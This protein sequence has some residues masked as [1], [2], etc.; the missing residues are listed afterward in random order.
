MNG[1]DL[2]FGM[3]TIQDSFLAETEELP[4]NQKSRCI[5]KLFLIAA[6]ISSLVV[7]AFAGNLQLLQENWFDSFFSEG[8]RMIAEEQLS[9]HQLQLLDKS[10]TRIDQTVTNQGFSVTMESALCDG[11]RMLMKCRIDAPEQTVMDGVNYGISA[12]IEVLSAR[13]RERIRSSVM[14][15]SS[16]ILADEN[17]KDNSVTMLMEID[18]QPKENEDANFINGTIISISIPQIMELTKFEDDLTWNCLCEGNWE[19]NIEF[20]DSILCAESFEV[21]DKPMYCDAFMWVDNRILRNTNIPLRVK[22]TSI[23]LRTLSAAIN[24]KRP[25]V[26][27]YAGVNPNEPIQIVMHDGSVIT[28]KWK[29]SSRRSNFDQW[30]FVFS[31]SVVAKDVA[32]IDFPGGT[33]IPLS[34]QGE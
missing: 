28:G 17:P 14:S 10:L 6:I 12:D 9:E 32:Y 24:V 3:T 30:Y 18:Y 8:S 13:N 5:G 23:E 33:R 7:G 2:L 4:K 26:A 29:Q 34:N 11:Y 20:D 31:G 16:H 19:F 25:L 21:L 1:R 22:M 15:H 27:W